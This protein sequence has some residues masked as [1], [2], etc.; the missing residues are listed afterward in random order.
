MKQIETEGLV[1]FSRPYREKDRLVKIFTE[2]YGKHMFFVRRGSNQNFMYKTAIQ[3]LN[4]ANYIARISD[5]GL[6]FINSVKEEFS[7]PRIQLDFMKHAYATYLASLANA[8]IEDR[9][10]DPALYGFL[11]Q[12]LD[13][14]NQGYDED[15]IL[16]IFELQIMSRF[17]VQPE[18]RCC[19]LC[20]ESAMNVPFDYCSSTSGVI[21]YR[22]FNEVKNRYHANPRAVYFARLFNQI[23]LE[24][25]QSIHLA[26]ETKQQ[27]R[28]L[29]DQLYDEY[30]GLDLKS[31][32]FLQKMGQENSALL[33]AQ[34]SLIDKKKNHE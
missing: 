14:L 4:G 33:Q 13:Y 8:A 2:Q 20:G 11:K 3:P 7:Y 21:C 5:D 31:K 28:W 18:F 6:S 32:Q 23:S 10:Y 29:I 12:S 19:T 15:V 25:I 9:V 17:G 30:I 34:K 22:H 26:D 1:L 16:N 24:Q 27:I